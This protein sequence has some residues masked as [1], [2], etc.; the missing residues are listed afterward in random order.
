MKY[1]LFGLNFIQ[2][3]LCPFEWPKT[4]KRQS[5]PDK[6]PIVIYTDKDRKSETNIDL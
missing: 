2:D 3:H 1:V 6:N 5:S 4:S